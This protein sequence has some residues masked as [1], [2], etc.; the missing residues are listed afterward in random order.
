M[1]IVLA[2]DTVL[3]DVERD[4]Q[5]NVIH[6]LPHRIKPMFRSIV[7]IVLTETDLW[8]PDRKNPHVLVAKTLQD[9]GIIPD[10]DLQAIGKTIRFNDNADVVIAPLRD[11]LQWIRDLEDADV[12]R[13]GSPLLQ[14]SE[15]FP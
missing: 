12:D 11:A 10:L 1:D 14:N 4:L 13:N 6:R 8:D 5:D 15:R 2:H 9:E 3:Y 7:F